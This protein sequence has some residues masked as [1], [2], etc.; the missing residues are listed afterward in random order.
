M[1]RSERVTPLSVTANLRRCYGWLS[2]AIDSLDFAGF[3]VLARMSRTAITEWVR[4]GERVIASAR[5]CA[6]SIPRRASAM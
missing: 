2:K 1:R 5:S 6:G 4:V 3:R